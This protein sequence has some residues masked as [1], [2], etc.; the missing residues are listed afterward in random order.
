MKGGVAAREPR[1]KAAAAAAAEEE[2][3]AGGRVM[4]RGRD[5]RREDAAPLEDVP[6]KCQEEQE[7][8][9]AVE[10]KINHTAPRNDARN[11]HVP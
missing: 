6:S 8:Q 7:E 9:V 5:A 1:Y 10:W 3:E 2:E 4:N 11:E